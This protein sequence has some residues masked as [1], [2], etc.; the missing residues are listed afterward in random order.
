MAEWRL[1]DR[2]KTKE[3]THSPNELGTVWPTTAHAREGEVLVRLDN[4]E[5]Y[6]DEN[7]GH[8]FMPEDLEAEARCGKCEQH[9]VTRRTGNGRGQD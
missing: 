2:V 4:H 6:E 3:G 1:G 8:F 5:G 9:S 7:D